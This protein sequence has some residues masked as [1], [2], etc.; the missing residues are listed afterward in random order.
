MANYYQ[1]SYFEKP[2]GGKRTVTG[3][4]TTV[5]YALD[6]QNGTLIRPISTWYW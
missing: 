3:T 5:P 1:P 4:A 2:V 6:A